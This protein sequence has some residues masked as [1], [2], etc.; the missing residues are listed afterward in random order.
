MGH[1][2]GPNHFNP[3]G[4]KV[5]QVPLDRFVYERPVLVD[6]PNTTPSVR[7]DELES[8]ESA[9]AKADVLLLR[10]P[11][12]PRSASPTRSDTPTKA[13]ASRR[14]RAAYL[15]DGFPALKAIALDC[16]SLASYRPIDPEGIV[17]DQILSA[18]IS[19]RPPTC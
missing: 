2:D 18:S 3:D 1:V 8:H 4:I 7:R 12:G 17:A 6:V 11:A 15:M 5:A 13:P 14:M 16:I 10:A 19:R 9:I